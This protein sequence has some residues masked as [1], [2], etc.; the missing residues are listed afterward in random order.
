MSNSIITNSGS[1]I[2]LQALNG[3]ASDIQKTENEISTGLKVSSPKDDG[4]LWAAAQNM[5][6][7]AS[8]WQTV[9]DSLNRG[10]SI[11]DV[12]VSATQSISDLLNQMKTKALAYSDPTNNSAALA[13][14]QSD[15]QSLVSQL[16][17]VVSSASFDGT[18]IIDSPLHTSSPINLDPP[19]G[20]QT[21]P[22]TFGSNVGAGSGKLSINMTWSGNY[23]Y[24]IRYNGQLAYAPP[25]NLQEYTGLQNLIGSVP[26]SFN[27]GN[28]LQITLTSVAL[29][30]DPTTHN[31]IVTVNS[32]SFVPDALTNG[33]LDVISSPNGAT[34]SVPKFD[35]SSTAL[36]LS[37]LSWT[38]PAGIISAVDTAISTVNSAAA[39]IGTQ[40]SM[41]NDSGSLATQTQDSITT[42][43]GNL[44]DADVARAS[45]SLAAEQT[46]RQLGVQS[47]SIANQ[48]PSILLQL[49]N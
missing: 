47:L 7:Q 17:R 24:E 44:V 43:I 22:I 15:I 29:A 12:A 30:S 4:T 25:G 5:R 41:L 23:T 28:N 18:N 42:G 36:G 48:A 21:A 16:D 40:S 9:S 32:A 3:S 10:Q 35:L 33:S 14:Y 38:N 34:I 13:A 2:A 27:Q 8:G 1:L 37:N 11:V 19:A 49:F 20:P 6:G 39:E 31:G 26:A 46:K 45:A